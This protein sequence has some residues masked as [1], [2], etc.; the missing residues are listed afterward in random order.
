METERTPRPQWEKMLR[1]AV[2]EP[3]RLSEGYN[4]FWRYSLFN[5]WFVA[6]QLSERNLEPGPVATYKQWQRLG[7]QVR[8]GE[9][10][11]LMFVPRVVRVRTDGEEDEDSEARKLYFA[12]IPRWFVLS[13]TDGEPYQ[14]PS[15]PTW[16]V[17][18][19]VRTLDLSKGNF[20]YLDGN[21]QGYM[22]DGKT[23]AV[24]PIAVDPLKT[25]IHEMAHCLL[26]GQAIRDTAVPP[27]SLAEVEAE[28][29]SLLVRA[30]LG[31]DVEESRGYI[32]AWWGHE[33]IPP[34]SCHAI[35]TV[36]DKILH[37]GTKDLGGDDEKTE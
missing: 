23:F 27:I 12:C 24:S 1:Q 35:I 7:R 26:H 28:A 4:R 11:L 5:Q 17:E 25:T 19:A 2:S 15:L 18:L 21:V 9:R 33:E 6:T 3:G 14:P 8:K 32:Q 31:L 29:V 20:Q 37:A 16:D 22:I 36:A 13:Q 30:S 34:Q 10:A